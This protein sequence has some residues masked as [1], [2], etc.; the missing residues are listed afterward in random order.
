M[1]GA[2]QQFQHFQQGAADC[3]LA[4]RVGA[5]IPKQRLGQFQVPVAVFAPSEL[6]DRACVK[7]E[8]IGIQRLGSC[9][10]H[11]PGPGANP[12]IGQAGLPGSRQILALGVHQHE[13][14]RVPELVAEIA[15]ALGAGEVKAHVPAGGRQGAK[16]EAQGIGA[17][18]RDAAGKVP[19]RGLLN[20][21]RQVRLG[22]VAGALGHQVLQADA[23][24]QV[25][26][27]QSVALGLGHLLTFRIAHQAVDVHLAERHFA[28]E[29]Q[30]HHDHAGHP[31]ED[32]VVAGDQHIGRVEARQ[33]LGLLRPA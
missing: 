3:R 30:R 4:G 27:V 14:R 12:A 15:V 22:E 29:L 5:L 26:G 10:D 31:E 6:M 21:R 2:Q 23:I 1:G 11:L 25:Q 13:P 8:S 18:G 16:G 24:D 20:A 17:I 19:P 33:R 32:D 9:G 28:G 7:I